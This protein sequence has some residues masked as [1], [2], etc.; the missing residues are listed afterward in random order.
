MRIYTVLLI[1]LLLSCHS[2]QHLRYEQ[3][4]RKFYLEVTQDSCR[5]PTKNPGYYTRASY[6][7][8]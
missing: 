6:T 2:T 7:E 1:L 5:Q 4:T 3:E 8:P